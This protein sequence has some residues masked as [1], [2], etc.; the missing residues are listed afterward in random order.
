MEARFLDE[1]TVDALKIAASRAAAEGMSAVFLTTGPLG[2]AITLAG[3]LSATTPTIRL[4]IRTDLSTE[5]HRHPT[6]LG[7]D[8]TALDL[9][10]GGRAL[11][12]FAPPFGDAVAEAIDLCRA[13][14]RQGIA[15]SE[16]PLYPVAGAIN[17]PRPRQEGGPP[18]ALDLTDGTRATTALMDAADIL[19]VPVTATSPL[20]LGTLSPGTELCR[21]HLE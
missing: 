16:G 8:M 11:L 13:M 1:T 7:R 10:S 12:A 14:W 9:V 3:A 5:P 20:E 19:L 17:R 15:A 2:D 21:V 6:V 4:G 18:I